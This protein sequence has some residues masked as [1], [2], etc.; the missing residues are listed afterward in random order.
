M[1]K[2]NA[3]EQP[4]NGCWLHKPGKTTLCLLLLD[5][6][7]LLWA[8]V[9]AQQAPVSKALTRDNLLAP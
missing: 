3:M 4:L 9:P 8:S 7:L 6:L 1:A 5:R 2:G